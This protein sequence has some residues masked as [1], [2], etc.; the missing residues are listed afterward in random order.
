MAV[1]VLVEN[2]KEGLKWF[3]EGRLVELWKSWVE[4]IILLWVFGSHNDEKR[5]G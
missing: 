4:R 3:C 5:L 1:V 2:G